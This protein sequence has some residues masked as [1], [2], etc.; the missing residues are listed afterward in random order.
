MR[1]LAIFVVTAFVLALAATAYAAQVNKYE[2][3]GKTSPR[4]AGSKKKPKAIGI[5]FGFKVKEESGQRPAVVHK[6]AI[7]F[8]GTRVNKSAASTCSLGTLEDEGVKGCSKKSIVGTGFIENKTGNTADPTDTSI[9][10]NAALTV[11][12]LKGSKAAIYVEGDP[13][14]T[15]RRRKCA[16]Q[17]AA[18]IPATFKNTQSGSTLTFTVPSSLR[19]PGAPTISNAVVSVT[20]KIKKITRKGKGFYE[21]TGC[22]KGKR[23][24][25]VKFTTEAGDSKTESK[26]ARC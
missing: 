3:T 8:A 22:K 24:I 6:Y 21:A 4:T 12:N 10:C 16:I 25:S 17:L 1:K 2:I 5:S 23:K 7:T 26:N 13:N 19:H 20:S 9:L 18:P 14:Q 11:V 15:D